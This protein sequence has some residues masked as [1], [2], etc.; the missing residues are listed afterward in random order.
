MIG[1]KEMVCGKFVSSRVNQVVIRQQTVGLVVGEVL[2]VILLPGNIG[3]V[4]AVKH[5]CRG[6]GLHSWLCWVTITNHPVN[7][8]E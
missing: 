1:N 2:G 8:R 5:N 7:Q 6:S 4:V 3:H